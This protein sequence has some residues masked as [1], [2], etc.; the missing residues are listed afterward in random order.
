M[1]GSF[2]LPLLL[3]L[4]TLGAIFVMC[5]PKAEH[6]LHRGIGLFF[7]GASLLASLLIFSYFDP[8]IGSMQLVFDVEWIPSLGAHFKVGIDGIS[9]WLVILTT[10]LTP[11]TMLSAPH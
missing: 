10:F 7:S 11:L 3:A 5:T 8:R 2:I 1:P 9:V 6:S 4:P